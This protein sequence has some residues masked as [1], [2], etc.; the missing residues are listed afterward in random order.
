M[1]KLKIML[2]IIVFQA[3]IIFVFLY[4]SQT[5]KQEFIFEVKKLPRH[6]FVVSNDNIFTS[7]DMSK[8]GKTSDD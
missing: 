1:N 3:I 5:S 8:D 2:A 7:V 4:K 6:S